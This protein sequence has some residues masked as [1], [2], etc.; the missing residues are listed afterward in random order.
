MNRQHK[1]T[2]WLISFVCTLSLFGCEKHESETT[3]LTQSPLQQ[4]QTLTAKANYL[5][6]VER[7]FDEY[8]ALNPIAASYVGRM[9][10]NH[11]FGGDLSDHF[12]Q[13]RHQLNKAYLNKAKKL[14]SS[15]LPRELQLS[16]Q[17]FIYDRNLAL[18]DETFPQRFL[19]IN[20]FY[21]KL[22]TMLALGSGNSAQPFNTVTDYQNWLARIDGFILWL[23]RAQLRMDEGVASKVVLPRPIVEKIINQLNEII[24]TKLE[25]HVLYSPIQRLPEH[26]SEQQKSNISTQYQAMIKSKWQVALI[27]F[28]DYLTQSYLPES[29]G[30]DGWWALPNGK[31]WYQHLA[32]R[33]TTTNI[34]VDEIHLIGLQEV[35]RIRQ[36]MSTVA[37]QL[38]FNGKLN[39]FFNTLANDGNQYFNDSAELLDAY[40][41]V[42]LKVKLRLPEYFYQLPEADYIIKPVEDFREKTA[43][44][45]SYQV[46]ATGSNKPAI[47]YINTYNLKAQPKWGVTTLSL[48]EAMPGHHL[49]LSLTQSLTDIPNF[50]KFNT[51]TAFVEGWALYAEYLGIEM[52]LYDDPYQYFGMLSDELLRAMRLVVDTG[53]HAKGWSRKQAIYYMQQNSPMVDS[54]II[55]EVERYMAI[56][57]QAL[58]YKIGQLTILDLREQ[59]EEKLGKN[60]DLKAFHHQVLSSGAIPL[61]VL[62]EKIHGWIDKQKVSD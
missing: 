50:Q 54:D 5:T 53:L 37:S 58:A 23:E 26:F 56:P 39:D 57:G 16:L 9:Q 20:Q 33:H 28:R 12:L 14:D 55:A 60:F 3:V 52:G 19:P 42:K 44:G 38:G 61:E 31:L 43:A 4:T 48:H 29:R 7:Y 15:A 32:N 22:L 21:S 62:K 10:Y 41:K 24:D 45:A 13:S 46:A 49:Q 47:F 51:Y 27:Q 25:Q 18:V 40:Q 1:L 2:L 59:A 30:T 36:E 8:L 11:L 34:S 17:Q 6:L 35:K